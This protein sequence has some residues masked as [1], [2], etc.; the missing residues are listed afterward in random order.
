MNLNQ[1]SD[2]QSI[3]SQYENNFESREKLLNDLSKDPSHLIALFKHVTDS[4]SQWHPEDMESFKNVFNKVEALV[5]E[6]KIDEP[7]IRNVIK[8]F[9]NA[10]PFFSENN[11]LKNTSTNFLIKHV[12]DNINSENVFSYLKY[13]KKMKN[14]DS[15]N[16]CLD[17]YSR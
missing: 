16:K 17:S 2:I 13:A 4:K 8:I 1:K 6:K 15:I 7:Q 9:S 3:I 10:Y 12:G 11:E 5:N 14:D